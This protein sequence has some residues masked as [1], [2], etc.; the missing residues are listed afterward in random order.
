MTLAT[1]VPVANW[2]PRLP[3]PGAKRRFAG[4][5]PGAARHAPLARDEV[6]RSILVA[7]VDDLGISFGGPPTTRGKPALHT[8]IDESLVSTDLVALTGGHLQVRRR[9]ER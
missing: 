5:A 3:L 8:F 7:L 9:H 2:G 6:Q 4:S 1:F